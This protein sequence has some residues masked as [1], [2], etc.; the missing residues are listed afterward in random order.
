[1]ETLFNLEWY[2]ILAISTIIGMVLLTG[3]RLL[4]DW[5]NAENYDLQKR[6]LRE[7]EN[8]NNILKKDLL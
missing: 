1:M 2:Y 4:Y 6:I 5:L 8:T 7:L 3:M